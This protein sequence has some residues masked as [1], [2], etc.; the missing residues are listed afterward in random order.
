[1]NQSYTAFLD[2]IAFI[3]GWSPIIWIGIAVILTVLV[4]IGIVLL[5]RKHR[6]IKRAKEFILLRTAAEKE[7]Y[8]NELIAPSGFQYDEKKDMFYAMKNTWQK[9]Y[10]YSR[11]YDEASAPFGMIIDCEPI[12]FDYDGK[13]WMLELWKGQYGMTA[14]GEIGLYTAKNGRGKFF[15]GVSAE[16]YIGMQFEVFVRGVKLFER[17]EPHWWLTGFRL[18]ECALPHQ[19]KMVARLT[20]AN[21]LMCQSFV[22]GLRRAGYRTNEYQVFGESVKILFYTPHTKQPLTRGPITDWLTVSR[23]RFFCR[24][25]KRL[26]R[27]YTTTSD[28]LI[29]L[30]A[31]APRLFTRALR[32]GKTIK[33]FE[34]NKQDE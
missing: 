19:V 20:F 29:Y 22:N 21:R 16:D 3:L 12:Y 32:I 7:N 17:Q 18:G 4:V 6:R 5:Y 24:T 28:R 30:Q 26:T 31:K 15:Q 34:G 14:G 33:L 2:P 11:L 25:Y 1:M 13:K 9:R 27:R 23:S 8:I 10:G